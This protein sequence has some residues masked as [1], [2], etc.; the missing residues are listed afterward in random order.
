MNR[1]IGIP[2]D[3]HGDSLDGCSCWGLVRLFYR[4]EYSIDLPSIADGDQMRHMWRQVTQVRRGDVILFRHQG[5]A[6]HVSIALDQRD[7]LHVDNKPSCIERY[8][9]M[10]WKH[11]LLRIYRHR[12]LM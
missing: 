5:A 6:R 11:R 1:Y 7:M 12:D 3:A 4:D 8:R 9:G 2:W 10:V